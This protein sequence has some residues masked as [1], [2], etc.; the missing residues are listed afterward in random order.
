MLE[1]ANKLILKSKEFIIPS[2]FQF[3]ANVNP[4]IYTIFKKSHQYSVKSNVNEKTLQSFINNWV[5]NEYI[6]ITL[7]NISEY[8]QLSSEFDRIT[9]IIQ[10]FKKHYQRIIT[11]R[12]DNQEMKEKMLHKKKQIYTNYFKIHS[13]Q[14]NFIHKQ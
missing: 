10:E 9:D 6:E 7:D 13:N 1:T 14:Q 5:N 11:L 12:Q 3:M 2:D 4:D 8:E